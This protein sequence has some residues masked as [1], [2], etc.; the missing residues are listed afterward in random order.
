[1]FKFFRKKETRKEE[2][3]F[4]HIYDV[5]ILLTLPQG[6]KIN[7]LLTFYLYETYNGKRKADHKVGYTEHAVSD[8]FN[9]I[10]EYTHKIYPWLMGKDFD[11][12]PG[13]WDVVKEKRPKD[14]NRMYNRY[15]KV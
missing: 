7:R 4:V 10:I 15:F 5:K 3:V 2:Y 11:D 13:Y 1:M 8:N 12:I 9:N 14:I 6:D